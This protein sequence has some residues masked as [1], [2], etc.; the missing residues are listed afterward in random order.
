MSSLPGRSQAP[1]GGTANER[2]KSHP[3]R[4]RSKGPQWL[5]IDEIL[6]ELGVPRRTWQKWH[7]RKQTPRMLRLPNGEY[8]IHRD[9]YQA[10]LA[11]LE[12]DA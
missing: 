3:S 9:D 4:S 8:R 5:T 12:V 6:H 1:V 2:S 11:G 10:W 7:T